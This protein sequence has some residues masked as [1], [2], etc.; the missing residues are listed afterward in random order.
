MKHTA[1]DMIE[2][3]RAHYIAPSK[4][5]GGYFVPEL[6]APHSNRRADL[7]WLPL[8]SQERGRII[9]HEVKVS[10][11]DI[12]QELADPTKADAWAR[13]CSQWWLVV[14]DPDLLFGL[15]VPEHWGIMAPPSGRLRRSMTVVRPAPELRPE[16][17]ADALGTI[18]ARMFFAGDDADT[19]LSEAERRAER[20]ETREENWRAQHREMRDKLSALGELGY[21]QDL[22][23]ELI[24][25]LRTE[26]VGEL[27]R[28]ARP[29]AKVIA[30]AALNH[31]AVDQRTAQMIQR[32][33]RTVK[34]IGQMQDFSDVMEKLTGM[35]RRI[36]ADSGRQES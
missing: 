28:Y 14:S 15:A 25:A 12:I 29:D 9:G 8:T 24:Q 32:L 36:E 30:Q 16:D 5:A 1:K 19:R 33:D 18:L 13:Y 22:A 23:S 2:M 34:Q 26:R 6:T 7:I 11:A 21:E 4:P 27:L 17:R 35:R 20:A 3:L 10:R 31:A